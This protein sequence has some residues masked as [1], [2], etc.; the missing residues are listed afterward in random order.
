LE[1]TD[2]Y[3]TKNKPKEY[4]QQPETKKLNKHATSEMRLLPSPSYSRGRAC[5]AQSQR[6]RFMKTVFHKRLQYCGS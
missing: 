2:F 1:Q 5:K 4:S 3:Q 6:K